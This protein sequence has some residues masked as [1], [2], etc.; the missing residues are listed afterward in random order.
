[1]EYHYQIVTPESQEN[2]GNNIPLPTTYTIKVYATKDGYEKS[3]LA[4]KEF[5]ISAGIM[6]DTNNDGT[7]DATD[8]VNL[9]NVIMENKAGDVQ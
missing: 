8:I 3:D 9:V 1:M 4:V 2:V 7:I 5:E 6:G